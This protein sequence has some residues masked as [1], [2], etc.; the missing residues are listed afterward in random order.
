VDTILLLL[1]VF[2]RQRC[3][4]YSNNIEWAR[5]S[6]AALSIKIRTVAVNN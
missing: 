6:W 5:Y 3:G 2:C 4:H 1:Q